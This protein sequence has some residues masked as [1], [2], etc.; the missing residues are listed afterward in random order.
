MAGRV[1][2]LQS[3]ELKALLLVCPRWLQPIV[4][5]AVSTGMRRGEILGLRTLDRD[6]QG[7]RLLLPQTKNGDGRVVYLNRIAKA[8]LESVVTEDAPSRVL[9]FDGVCAEYVTQTFRQACTDVGIEDFRFHDLRHTAASWMRMSG[10][11]V[12]TVAL[13]LGHKDLR[14]TM[15]YSHLSP[16]F[17]GD[18]VGRLDGVFGDLRPHSVPAEVAPSQALAV[19]PSK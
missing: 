4:A 18:T 10:A 11:D 19:T 6:F 13:A 15:Q 17:L 14:M 9:V 7:N 2:Y 8:A 5:L 16:A 3:T 1:R 12:H